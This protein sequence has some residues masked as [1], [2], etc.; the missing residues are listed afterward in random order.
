MT[1]VDVVVVGGGLAGLS[2]ARRLL[3]RGH[4]VAVL[5]ARDVRPLPIKPNSAQLSPIKRN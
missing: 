4:R 2:A 5:E 1:D 3:A